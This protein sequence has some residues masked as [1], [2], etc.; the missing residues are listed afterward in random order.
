MKKLLLPILC[1]ALLCVILMAGC[2]KE[3]ETAPMA[4][5]PETTAADA[6]ASFADSKYADIGKKAM[7]DLAKG[8]VDGWMAMYA[9]N[10]KYYWNSGDSLVG[11]PA[12][13]KFWRDRRMN[14][15]ETLEFK[16]DIWLPIDVHKPQQMEAAGVWLLAWYQVTVK[17]K[18]GSTMTQ[19]MHLDF[20]F[21]AKDKI[22]E[23]HQYMDRSLIMA[24]MPKK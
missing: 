10:A 22:E 13:D 8:D 17:Y 19:W 9:D 7:A 21:D 4:A 24:A 12:I 3:P 15:I 11:K 5:T 18:G 23:V 16:N 20:H 1:L 2:K 14:T 6:P